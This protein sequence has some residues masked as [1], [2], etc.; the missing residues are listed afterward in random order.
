MSVLSQRWPHKKFG[1]AVALWLL[2]GWHPS[3]WLTQSEGQ[4]SLFSQLVANPV[5]ADSFANK[6]V[7]QGFGRAGAGA[8]QTCP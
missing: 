2:F 4:S 1:N 3:I 7:M 6:L 8:N 5:A